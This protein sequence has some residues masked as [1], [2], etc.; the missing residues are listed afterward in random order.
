MPATHS[1][2]TAQ[3]LA[4]AIAEATDLTNLLCGLH[5]LAVEKAL[6]AEIIRLRQLRP[7]LHTDRNRHLCDLRTEACITRLGWD[8]AAVDAQMRRV[9]LR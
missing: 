3:D 6:A 5:G 7:E 9:G 8:P 4:T 1:A 2:P